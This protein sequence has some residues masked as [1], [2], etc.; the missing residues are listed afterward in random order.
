MHRCIGI[1]FLRVWK[2]KRG[3]PCFV[4][5]EGKGFL[6]N[7]KTFIGGKYRKSSKHD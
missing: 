6:V 3:F 7:P 1:D 2:E 4:M 5:K